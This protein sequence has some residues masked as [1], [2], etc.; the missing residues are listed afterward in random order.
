MAMTKAEQKAA[1]DR[2]M[3][4]LGPLNEEERQTYEMLMK[5]PEDYQPPREKRVCGRCGAEFRDEVNQKGEVVVSALE[6]FSDHQA[7]HNPSPAQWAEAHR[8][9]SAAKQAKDM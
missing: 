6:K 4:K 1:S 7:E 8:R 5:R 3:A 9:I 2:I